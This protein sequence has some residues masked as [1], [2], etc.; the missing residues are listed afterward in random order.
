MSIFDSVRLP[1]VGSSTFDMSCDN[2][3]STDFGWLTPVHFQEVLPG[4]DFHFS[5][6]QLIR[7]APMV[8]P[9]MHEVNVCMH[10][11]FVP[12]RILWP[13]WENFI[14]GG[15]DGLAAP[16]MP[17]LPAG[18]FV[19]GSLGDYLGVPTGVQLSGV[20]AFTFSAYQKIYD[21]FYRDQ[22]LMPH[23]WQPLDDGI[24]QGDYGALTGLRRR[25]WE[26]DYFTSALPWAQKGAPVKLPITGSLNVVVDNG[27]P[28]VSGGLSLDSGGHIVNGSTATQLTG[29]AVLGDAVNMTIEDLRRSSALQRWLERNARSGSRYVENLLSHFGVR[30]QDSRLDRPE[31]LGGSKSPVM[32]SEVLQQSAT[33]PSSTPLGEMAGQGINLGKGGDLHYYSHEHGVIMCLMSVLPKSGYYQGI[34]RFYFKK[35]RFDFYWPE[36]Q[37]VG[38]QPIY[39]GEL[40][41]QAGALDKSS[42][43]GVEFGYVPRYAE[44]KY[45]LSTVH[46]DFRGSLD[47]WHMDRKFSGLPALNSTFVQCI[48]D[49]RNFAVEDPAY[50]HLY[51][52]VYIKMSARRKMKY[53]SNPGSII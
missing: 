33:Q 31:Y 32:I 37:G 47:Y 22:N 52:H 10:W 12:Y 17:V 25:A 41:A 9:V 6:Q 23:V 4:D 8:A 28:A 53:Y 29:T 27:T 1:K 24:Y 13:N 7:L 18:S 48:P 15:D 16:V 30:S 51:C 11:F 5:T 26:H 2:K 14:T 43:N 42:S 20:N 35:D 3:L 38:E 21:D 19:N 49:N 50:G 45:N 36:F 46:G 40:Y 44:Y 34:N 39:N